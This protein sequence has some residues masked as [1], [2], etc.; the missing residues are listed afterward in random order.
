MWVYCGFL[1]TL[2]SV[3]HHVRLIKI[4]KRSPQFPFLFRRGTVGIIR[5]CI[6]PQTFPADYTHCWFVSTNLCNPWTPSLRDA[7]CW[8]GGPALLHALYLNHMPKTKKRVGLLGC[9]VKVRIPFSS[10][11]TI[12][13]SICLQSGYIRV[14]WEIC[15]C[16]LQLLWRL[17]PKS[18]SSTQLSIHWVVSLI[19][20]AP[21]IMRENEI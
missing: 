12:S 16:P 13:K 7:S 9:V 18:W 15:W 14:F 5:T 20:G 21:G 17:K 10:K 6:F 4:I 8:Q 11:S 2:G 3:M 1:T 19:P